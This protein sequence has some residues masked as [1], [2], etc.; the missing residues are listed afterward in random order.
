MAKQANENEKTPALTKAE[1]SV[2]GK[3]RHGPQFALICS[4]QK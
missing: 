4:L 2:S 1:C 3:L